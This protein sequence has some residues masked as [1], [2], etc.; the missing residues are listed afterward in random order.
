MSREVRL[1]DH[2]P[3]LHISVT[4]VVCE[5][6]YCGAV[7]TE[8]LKQMVATR[9]SWAS[10]YVVPE[11]MYGALLSKQSRIPFSHSLMIP[12]MAEKVLGIARDGSRKAYDI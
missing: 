4:G 2:F 8:F 10:L 1:L 7:T 6:Q 5:P 3:N 9:S 12:W 11:N